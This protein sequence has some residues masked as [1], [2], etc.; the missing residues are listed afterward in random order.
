M[1]STARGSFEVTS[2]RE[3]PFDSVDGVA[4]ARVTVRKQFQGDLSGSATVHMLAVG[5]PVEGSAAY[6]AL[7][8]VTATLGGRSGT[9]VLHHT[10]SMGRGASQLRVVVAPDSGTG[11]LRGLSG[12]MTIEITGGKHFYAFEY[13]FD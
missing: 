6:V 9:F 10:G 1:T 2:Q 7:E 11:A 3:P 12:Q 4:M 5:S 13:S 8:R